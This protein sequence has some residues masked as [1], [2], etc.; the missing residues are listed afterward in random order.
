MKCFELEPYLK[1]KAPVDRLAHTCSI[2]AFEP[3]ERM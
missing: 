3:M 1:V 2:R